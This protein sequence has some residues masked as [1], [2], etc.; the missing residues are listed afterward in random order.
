VV[1]AMSAAGRGLECGLREESLGLGREAVMRRWEE[2]RAG[3]AMAWS[4][5]WCRE[6]SS[7]RDGRGGA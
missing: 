3:G 4:S 1:R 6:L 7:A 2:D 5:W